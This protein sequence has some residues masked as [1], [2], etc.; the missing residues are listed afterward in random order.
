MDTGRMR[1]YTPAALRL[2]LEEHIDSL[3]PGQPCLSD[4]AIA[5]RWGISARTVRR[6]MR[7][8]C[9]NGLVVRIQGKGTFRA[10]ENIVTAAPV[11]PARQSSVDRLVESLH[12]EIRGGALRRGDVLPKLKYVSLQYRVSERTVTMAY[13]RL[14]S[15]RIVSKVG[16]RYWV[17]GMSVWDPTRTR[18][19]AWL[20]F[21]SAERLESTFT[22]HM[23]AT[24]YQRF[25][26]ELVG[27]GI[28]LRCF[29]IHDLSSRARSASERE[30]LPVGIAFTARSSDYLVDALHLVGRELGDVV[31]RGVRVLAEATA[32]AAFTHRPPGVEA[33]ARGHLHTAQARALAEYIHTRLK[34]PVVIVRDIPHQSDLARAYIRTNKI[35]YAIAG[36]STAAPTI[37]T[38]F[39]GQGHS[40][41]VAPD[42]LSVLRGDTP[43]REYLAAEFDAGEGSE[44][45][46]G[47]VRVFGGL[48]EVCCACEGPVVWLCETSALAVESLRTLRAHGRRVPDDV[49]LLSLESSPELV[50]RGI[51]SCGPDMRTLGYLMAH[52]LVGDFRLKR[53]SRGFIR[54]PGRV[55]ER[56]TTP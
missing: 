43:Q 16:K 51:S 3:E 7:R 2:W 22:Q 1:T 30:T 24:A 37:T 36:Y 41:G 32:I 48:H 53:T 40:P 14:A 12:A 54:V 39:V 34:R 9:D 56:F 31:R 25:E 8:L 20:V 29:T 23:F 11:P 38:A 15:M 55:T 4:Q 19:E 26:E 6:A 35:A 46:P 18:S 17:G 28:A 42:W 10:G 52:A 27:C 47:D 5:A 49:A 50:A 45:T 13:R 33:F 21:D 44:A